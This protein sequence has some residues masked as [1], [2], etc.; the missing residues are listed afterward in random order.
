MAT[1]FLRVESGDVVGV[2]TTHKGEPPPAPDGVEHPVITEEQVMQ[3]GGSLTH[4]LG[5]TLKWRWERGKLVEQSD[6]R[7][8]LEVTFSRDE[9]AVGTPVTVTVRKVAT[10]GSPTSMGP[11][12][13]FLVAMFGNTQR[14][15]RVKL[16]NGRASFVLTSPDDGKVTFLPSDY[17]I[18]EGDVSIKSYLD[19]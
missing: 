14:L 1:H 17:S 7:P 13:V 4:A 9:V 6:P 16:T 5:G 10:A 15:F 12:Y 3:I 19:V 8:K 11:E 2:Q 18:V